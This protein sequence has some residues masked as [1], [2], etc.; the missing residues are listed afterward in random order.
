MGGESAERERGPF[1]RGDGISIVILRF[2]PKNYIGL[3]MIAI[4]PSESESNSVYCTIMG[5]DNA[6]NR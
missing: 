4:I 1:Y 3:L 2:Q 6:S 5:E